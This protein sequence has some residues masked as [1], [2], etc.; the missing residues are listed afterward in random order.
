M[1]LDL[2]PKTSSL[3]G[4][5]SLLNRMEVHVV[6]F[7]FAALF[8]GFALS[9]VKKW[10]WDSTSRIGLDLASRVAERSVTRVDASRV[11]QDAVR[12]LGVL[13]TTI[14]RQRGR[15]VSS[16]VF[17]TAM[18]AWLMVQLPPKPRCCVIGY[19]ASRQLSLLGGI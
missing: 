6:G 3:K 2:D 10:E 5:C 11:R 8:H 18:I 7:S 19:D 12:N 1:S 9:V 14:G 16:V 13:N 15:V 17:T 4:Y